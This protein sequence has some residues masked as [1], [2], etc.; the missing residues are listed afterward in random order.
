METLPIENK[1]L[2]PG[3]IY[4][5]TQHNNDNNDTIIELDTQN[6]DN[7]GNIIMSPMGEAILGISQEVHPL[8]TFDS[9]IDSINSVIFKTM[10]S[11]KRVGVDEYSGICYIQEYSDVE[12]DEEKILEDDNLIKCDRIIGCGTFLN[13][14]GGMVIY[15][16][17]NQIIFDYTNIEYMFHR[18]SIPI[19]FTNLSTSKIYKIK[20]SNGEI[21]NCIIDKSESLKISVSRDQISISLHFPLIPLENE[22]D[23]INNT[24]YDMIK[25]IMLEEFLILNQISQF[26]ITIPEYYKE[27][28]YIISHISSQVLTQ[29]NEHYQVSINKHLQTY[30]AYLEKFAISTS[31]EGNKLIAN[32]T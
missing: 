3:F 11:S 24:E 29:L 30:Q 5:D 22:S 26:V 32:L 9:I 23:S 16:H 13:I 12:I 14:P 6:T 31:I 4:Q 8:S 27:N 18:V 25:T 20:R 15:H 19:I 2:A 21:H 7:T 28:K 10:F 1:Y 17:S